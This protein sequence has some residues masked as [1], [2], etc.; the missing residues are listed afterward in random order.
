MRFDLDL[1]HLELLSDTSIESYYIELG[2]E[3]RTSSLKRNNIPWVVGI[4]DP[5]DPNNFLSFIINFTNLF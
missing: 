5:E 3:I 2:G 4:E 1:V